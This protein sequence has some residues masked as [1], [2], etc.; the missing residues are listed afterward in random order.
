MLVSV[1]WLRSL[2]P[3]GEGPAEVARELTSRGLPVEAV[4]EV[5]GDTVLELDVPANRPDCL[6]HRGV[7][8][9]LAAAFGVPLE[10][11]A[12]A[13]TGTGEPIERHIRVE[14]LDA[15]LCP[16]YTARVVRDVT[17]QPSPD[18]VVRRLE[19][20]GLR[21]V[22]NVVDASNLVLL[23]LGLPIH[24]FDLSRLEGA[25]IIIRRA[26]R[27]EA[28]R[29]LDGVDRPLDEQVLVIA[30]AVRPVALAGI[31]GG[32][33]SE[34]HH[35]SRD[36]VIEAAYFA[37]GSIRSTGKRLGLATD[38][39][40]RFER[41]VDPEG[42]VAAQEAAVKLLVELAGGRPVPGC[43]D[44][45]R[46]SPRTP[47]LRLRPRRFARLAG[48][49]PEPGEI[50]SALVALG[51]GVE[52]ERNGSFRVSVPSWRVDLQREEDLV[53]EVA[54]QLGYDRIPS[55]TGVLRGEQVPSA[56]VGALALEERT[57]DIL[58][59]L[60]FHEAF[61]YSMLARGDDD[62]F[63]REDAAAAVAL[64]NPIAEPM[65]VLRR[66][67]LPGLLRAVE[68][69]LRRGNHDVRLFEVGRVFEARGCAAVPA[70]PLRAGV[71][72]CGAAAPGHWSQPPREVGF[73][74]LAGV[75]E[76]LL[77][78]L[79]PSHR[80]ARRA[81]A[82]AGMHPGISATWTLGQAEAVAW[83]GALHPAIRRK[84]DL[85]RPVL[86]G[87]LDLE[88]LTEI[89]PAIPAYEPLPRVPAVVRDLS[90]VL[91]PSITFDQLLE[92]ARQVPTPAPARFEVVDRYEGKPLGP[93]EFSLTLRVTLEPQGRT[94]TDEQIES[95]RAGLVAALREWRGIRLRG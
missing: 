33:D 14:I 77:A 91:T 27:G 60:G 93:G 31:M 42:A 64:A 22:N 24:L 54:R 76:H 85:P 79:R 36:V 58:A 1:A 44:V 73:H 9:E 95:Y 53:E 86:L 83:C 12:T 41:G 51:L 46:D 35:A 94:L 50:R 90:L 6:G 13:P 28:L 10:P 4:M 16:R 65:A 82:V 61:S 84:L 62:P 38:A 15:D 39:S 43:I 37:P 70:E 49:E 59:H 56:A 47:V 40:Y 11:L 75:L 74:D 87:E 52:A 2:C 23:E 34:I 92:V 78:A 81:G 19:A 25:T 3:F 71:A 72:W 88:R 32:A 80:P 48:Y 5:G 55:A 45:R 7:A 20:C 66:S 18:W 26:R 30:D 89:A 57:R 17:V 63:V 21:S 69:N 68:L 29:T 8:R 67:L